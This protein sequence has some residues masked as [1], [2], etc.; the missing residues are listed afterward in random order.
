MFRHRDE[1]LTFLYEPD[2]EATNWMAEQAIR[3]AVVNRK[4]FGGNRMPAGAHAQEIL[5][6]V[7]ATCSQRAHDAMCFVSKLIRATADRRPV[8]VQRLLPAPTT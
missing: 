6:S 4:V 5:G 2:L 7:F 1:I 3:P 8:L